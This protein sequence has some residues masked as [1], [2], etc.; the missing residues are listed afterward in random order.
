MFDTFFKGSVDELL[1]HVG[2]APATEVE[3]V[4][5]ENRQ[6][7]REEIIAY[8]IDNSKCSREEAGR[9]ATEL[10]ME[11]FDRIVKP[12]VEGGLL[13]ITKYD[14]DGQPVYKPTQKSSATSFS[15]N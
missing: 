8:I 11:E 5:D 12:M 7:N 10:Q 15:N 6:L 4:A 14:K 2:T 1:A 9:I 13:E 3:K